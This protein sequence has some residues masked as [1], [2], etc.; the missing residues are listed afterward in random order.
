MSTTAGIEK[1]L[2]SGSHVLVF[3]YNNII[4]FSYFIYWTEFKKI[5]LRI[6]IKSVFST[7]F[8]M[9][10]VCEKKTEM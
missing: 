8:T 7:S 5:W 1:Q 10:A 6:Q 2:S 9:S 4:F 3:G